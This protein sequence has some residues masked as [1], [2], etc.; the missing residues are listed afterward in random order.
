MVGFSNLLK[1]RVLLQN[2]IVTNFGDISKFSKFYREYDS[3]LKH[4]FTLG[5]VQILF[6][7]KIQNTVGGWKGGGESGGG[8]LYLQSSPRRM[9][10]D[11]KKVRLKKVCVF[12]LLGSEFGLFYLLSLI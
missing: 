5:K 4:N 12:V 10:T 11:P 7:C 9:S 3:K 1:Q 6:T 8:E 2:C